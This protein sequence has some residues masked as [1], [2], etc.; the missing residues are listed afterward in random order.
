MRN[1]LLKPILSL[2]VLMM[3][4]SGCFTQGYAEDIVIVDGL[5]KISYIENDHAFRVN[6][7]NEDGSARK[8][9]F[10]TFRF[11]GGL[12]QSGGRVA[13]CDACIFADI[14][15]TEEQVSDEFGAGTSYTFTFTRPDNGDDVQMVQRFCVY[16]E[17][18]FLITDLSIEGT[19]LYVPIIWLR[20]R[21]VRCMF[22]FSESEDNRMLKVP[23]DNDGWTRYNKYKMNT[24]MTSYEVAAWFNGETK[25][26]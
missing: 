18:D 8:C 1:T 26:G 6:V 5:W 25:E 23:F 2:S 17:N 15:Q 9:L 21:S 11:R 16:E 13:Y 20:Y 22:S 3:G 7:L 4:A 19:R 24:S 10:H 12:R 14:K